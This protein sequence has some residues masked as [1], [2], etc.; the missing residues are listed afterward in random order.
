[1]A[2]AGVSAAGASAAGSAAGAP[3]PQAANKSDKMTMIDNRC[4]TFMYP[5]PLV[6]EMK[7]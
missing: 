3:P 4:F 5:T 7:G 1:V 2:S 6:L